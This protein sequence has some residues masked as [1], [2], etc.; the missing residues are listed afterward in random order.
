MEKLSI[1]ALLLLTAALSFAQAPSPT[2]HNA[3]SDIYAGYVVNVPDYAGDGAVHKLQGYE[4]A[5]TRHFGSRWGLTASGGQVISTGSNQNQWQ[6]TAG[7]RFNVLTGRFRPYGT[8]QFGI[9]NQDSD[10][11]HPGV[12][13]AHFSRR[14]ALTYRVGAGADYQL[15]S[16]LYWRMGQWTAQAVPWGRHASSLFQNF[17]TGVGYQF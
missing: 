9:S 3:T 10:S 8:G 4:I 11:L 2:L 1:A 17:S 15:T 13:T 12:L 6:F 7:P 5:F 14:N 16:H